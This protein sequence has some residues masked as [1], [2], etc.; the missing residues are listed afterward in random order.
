MCMV[1]QEM[2]L[3]GAII[4]PGKDSYMRLKST[5]A[6]FKLILWKCRTDKDRHAS[7]SLV[8]TS[9]LQIT[10]RL[11]GMKSRNWLVQI[12]VLSQLQ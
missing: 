2:P 8:K 4:V 9:Y 12:L 7:D 6:T 1:N 11:W 3:W 5:R 10:Q